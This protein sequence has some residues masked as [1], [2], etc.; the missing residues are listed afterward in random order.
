M[1]R[2]YVMANR[3]RDIPAILALLLF[4]GS[5]LTNAD[6][7]MADE[8]MSETV[9]TDSA[10]DQATADLRVFDTRAIPPWQSFVGDKKGWRIPVSGSATQSWGGVVSVSATD[11]DAQEDALRITWSGKGEGQFFM[12]ADT[13]QDLTD[14]LAADS[15]LV[16][17]LKV[18]RAPNK[19]V[20]VRMDCQ[21]PCG[22]KGDLTELLR[23]IPADTWVALAIDL[24]CFANGGADF[25]RI[26]TP[27]LLVTRGKLT[28][29][30]ADIRIV[31]GVADEAVIRCD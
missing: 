22:A 9:E 18:E 30:T 2:G 3:T 15:A 14:L 24:Q 12:Q 21:H 4:A 1:P 23:K 20:T 5:G 19:G 13:P 17:Y 7:G 10:G 28:V 11:R 29:V 26:D 8:S 25:S 16:I 27:F 6:A 31:P